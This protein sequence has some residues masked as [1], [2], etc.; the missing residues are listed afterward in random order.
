VRM[1]LVMLLILLSAILIYVLVRIWQRRRVAEATTVAAS[2]VMTPDLN[3]E[4]I[5]ADELSTNHWLTLA[6]EM[7]EK[8]ELRL[9]VRALYLATLAKLAEQDMITIEAYKSNRDYEGE[10]K[11]RAHEYKELLSIFSSSL[12]FFERVWYGMYRIEPADF[13][14]YAT[15]HQRIVTFAEK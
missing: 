8:G 6:R 12:N 10:L 7:A 14:G 11:R 3:D 9:A 4:S 13:N 5:R 1:A 2:P 15:E